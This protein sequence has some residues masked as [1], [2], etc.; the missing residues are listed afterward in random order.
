MTLR[1]F[2]HGYLFTLVQYM[3]FMCGL[4]YSIYNW[5]AAICKEGFIR[6]ESAAITCKLGDGKGEWSDNPP[7]CELPTQSM[8]QS[9][10]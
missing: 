9:S 5:K 7:I 6:K 3:Y 8:C 2:P 10:L 4:G 1:R